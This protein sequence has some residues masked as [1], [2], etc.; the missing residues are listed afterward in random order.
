MSLLN[1]GS[2]ASFAPFNDPPHNSLVCAAVFIINGPGIM[3]LMM[4]R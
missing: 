3:F 1:S 2:L 4:L